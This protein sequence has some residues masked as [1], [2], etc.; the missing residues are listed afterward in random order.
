MSAIGAT[1]ASHRTVSKRGASIRR[2][3]TRTLIYASVALGGIMFMFPFMWAVL[4]SGKSSAEIASFPPTWWPDNN[5]FVQ[6]Y[7]EIWTV[8]PFGRW[9]LNSVT[10]T[11]LTLLGSIASASVTA[12]AFARFRFRGRNFWFMV[13][14]STMMI[15]YEVRLIPSYL[16]FHRLG[17]VNTIKP[18]VVPHWFAS[19]A[20]DVFLLRQFYMT[21][22]RELDE[23]AVMDGASSLRIFLTI[24]LPLSK[25]AVATAAALGFVASW[26]NFLGPLIYLTNEK[27]FTAVQGLRYF[28]LGS[29]SAQLAAGPPKDNLLMAASVVVALP[30]LILFF[31][32]Q[33]YFVQG[34]ATTGLKG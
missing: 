21:V 2:A 5:L 19:R 1:T 34:I 17:W 22:P 13:M 10:I 15:P 11:A 26:N 18:L 28:A 7:T 6:N 14:L 20:F 12:Y 29:S 24:L 23:A 8:A 27:K 25:P 32:A 30:C 16:I 3:G 31:V 9:V 4:S 33:R